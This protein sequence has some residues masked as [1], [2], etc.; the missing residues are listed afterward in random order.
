MSCSPRAICRRT[1]PPGSTPSHLPA[2]SYA[3]DPWSADIAAGLAADDVVL[4]LGTGLTMVD[5]ALL[6]DA[7]GFRGRIVALSRRGLLP[8]PHADGVPKTVRPER[9]E[10]TAVGLLRA[11]RKR[12]GEIEWRAAVDELRPY[13]QSIWRAMALPEQRRFLRHLRA[14]WDVHRH[15]LA[16][17]VWRRIEAMRERPAGSTSAPP[18]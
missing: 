12:S 11:M 1:P 15:R 18:S 9:P 4:V 8:H 6:L 7:A 10:P 16:P 5:I 3:A 13:T 2:G 14:W 17:S